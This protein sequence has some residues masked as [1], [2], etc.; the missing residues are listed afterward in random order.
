[1]N[2]IHINQFE[3]RNIWEMT[4]IG[5]NRRIFIS[6]YLWSK[7]RWNYT[8]GAEHFLKKCC[9]KLSSSGLNYLDQE[10]NR[11][12]LKIYEVHTTEGRMHR[13]LM[14]QYT[15]HFGRGLCLYQ[16][17]WFSL[18]IISCKNTVTIFVNF[19]TKTYFLL[20]LYNVRDVLNSFS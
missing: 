10:K 13:S 14:W 6:V 15:N 8:C 19:H 12:L 18:K 1:M 5:R 4:N 20:K 2:F 11:F 17:S 16:N 9:Q 7:I 3:N